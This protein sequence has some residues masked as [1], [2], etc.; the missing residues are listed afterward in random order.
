MT[1]NNFTWVQTHKELSEYLLT[2]EHDQLGLINL[3]KSI[4]ITPF[5]DKVAA[6]DHNIELE[7]I[8]PFTFFCYLYKYGSSR[9]LKNLQSIAN[10]LNIHL[11]SDDYGIPSAQ[12]QKVWLFPYK[13]ERV[14]NEV[15]RLWAFFKVALQNTITEDDWDDVLDIRSVGKTKLTEALFYIDPE[16][17]F[18][19]DGPTKP[20]LKEKLGID[21]KFDSYAEYMDLLEV[22]KEKID[23]PFYNLS[24][25]SYLWYKDRKQVNYWVF[26][27]NPKVYDFVGTIKNNGIDR[28]TISAHINRIKTGDKVIVWITGSNAG[29]YALAEITKDPYLVDLPEENK[30]EY[31]ADISIT[32]NLVDQPVTKSDIK[33]EKKLD[34]LKAGLQG[35]NF[36]AT[37]E[38]YQSLLDIIEGRGVKQYWLYSPGENATEWDTFYDTGIMGLGWDHLGDLSDFKSKGEI[39]DELLKTQ[40]GTGSRKNDVAANFDFVHSL[41]KGDIVICKRG[42]SELIGYGV[43]SSDYFFDE[44]R[45]LF[46]SCRKVDWKL[47]GTWSIDHKLVL[48]T[49]TDITKIPSDKSDHEFFYQRLMET[50]GVSSTKDNLHNMNFPLNTILYG[51]P[52]TGKTYN[53]ILKAAKIIEDR[54]FDSF[55]DAQKVFNANLGDRIEFI[56]FHQN[57]SYEDF[58]QGLRPEVDNQS[59]LVFDKKDGVF[60]RIA[61]RALENWN[62]SEKAPEELTSDAQFNIAL[63][64]Y[65]EL[66]LETEDNYPINNTAYITEV[67]EDAFRYTGDKWLKHATGIR[68]KYSDLLEFYRS[69]VI[70]R[71]DVK[72]LDNVSG[73][74][75]QH[76]TYYF[77][78]YDQIL[79][80]LPEDV[81]SSSVVQKQ[82]YVIIIDEI[83]RANISRVFGEL[84]TLIEPDKRANGKIPLKVQLPS[85]DRFIV[86]SNL[87]IIGTMNTADKSI[88]L[89]DIA[90]RRR[91]EFEPMYPRYDIGNIQYVEVL[92]KLNKQIISTKGHDF[93]IGHSYFMDDHTDLAQIMNKKVIPLLLEYYMND[94][95]EVKGILKNAGL[96]VEED[97]WPL[98]VI[99]A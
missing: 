25:D 18:P 83:N 81:Q 49:L 43:V 33:L 77:L 12:A 60:K 46:K 26:Q 82:N 85:G 93:Q 51:P 30:S 21:C 91:F 42:R 35:T 54:T 9:R 41:K 55:E 68:M 8:D 47:K 61:D 5:N 31:K 75:K 14:N 89:L 3:L 50:M 57:Y 92:K 98:K 72:H 65:Q 27:G 99:S 16:K 32:H 67:E 73:L 2:M 10:K 71:K 29:C 7:E 64:R 84:I 95:Q 90:L 39:K 28:W 80:Y 45:A 36:S 88:A 4:G 11:P 69:K 20:Y 40:E 97:V 59:S 76:A 13:Y 87:Y 96:K 19:I 70:S 79:K 94:E 22:I 53:T 78:V 37:E 52:G 86:P 15:P 1:D 48:K 24:Y 63:E 58:I 62:L 56:T 74:A 17:Y 6:G 23:I 44:G 38:E 66:I 34:N